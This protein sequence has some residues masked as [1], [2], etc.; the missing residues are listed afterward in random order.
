MFQLSVEKAAK[1]LLD[2]HFFENPRSEFIRLYV[3]PRKSTRGSCL[4]LKPDAKGERDLV[5]EEAG[6][7]FLL[8]KHLADQIGRW[9]KVSVNEKGG[10]EISSEKTF[11]EE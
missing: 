8:S 7:R 5:L 11:N 1:E 9:A 4:A 10:F 3:R 6:Y 2:N